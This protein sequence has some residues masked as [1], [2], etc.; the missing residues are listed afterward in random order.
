MNTKLLPVLLLLVAGSAAAQNGLADSLRA[1]GKLDLAIKEYTSAFE[2]DRSY[3]D[4]TYALASAYALTHY[5]KDKA[6]YYLQFALET[7][8]SLW[9]LADPDMIALSDDPRW[10]DIEKRQLANYQAA[11]GTLEDPDYAAEL[12]QLIMK[13]QALDYQVDLAR[14]YYMEHTAHSRIGTIQLPR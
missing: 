10:Q 7:D 2:N 9:V 8:S 6:F 5:Q 11:N 3:H 12:L 14:S 4:N 1:V 13:D